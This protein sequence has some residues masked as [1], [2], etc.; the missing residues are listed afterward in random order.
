MYLSESRLPALSFSQISEKCV[1]RSWLLLRTGTWHCGCPLAAL[2]TFANTSQ[3]LQIVLT[4]IS[5]DYGRKTIFIACL[6]L[7]YL[8][9]IPIALAQNIETLMICRFLA[10]FMASPIFNVSCQAC[11][12]SVCVS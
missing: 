6:T 5:E 4:P 11:Y 12:D 8:L 10:G 1:S 3:C 7:V 2:R 9:H